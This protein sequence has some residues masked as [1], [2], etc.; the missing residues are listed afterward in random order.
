[1]F[2]KKQKLVGELIYVKSIHSYLKCERLQ[3][4]NIKNRKQKTLRKGAQ[5]TYQG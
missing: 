5:K 4:V 3:H 2:L 1:M